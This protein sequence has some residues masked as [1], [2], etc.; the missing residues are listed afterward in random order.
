MAAV[1]LAEVSAILVY[2][3]GRPAPAVVPDAMREARGNTEHVGML[4]YT[5]FLIPFELV[6][7]LL[8]V[9]MIGAIILARKEY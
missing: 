6:S 8:L 7:M 1:L 3:A 4:L 5:D 2:T 9:A